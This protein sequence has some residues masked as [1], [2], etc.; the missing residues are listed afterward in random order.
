M[1]NMATGGNARRFKAVME[2]NRQRSPLLCAGH[3]HY[4]PFDHVLLLS[5]TRLS[6]CRA[7]FDKRA[8][9]VVKKVEGE[10]ST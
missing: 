10:K 3:Q 9:E 8:K 5:Q 7:S 1:L 2:E 6:Y 4:V